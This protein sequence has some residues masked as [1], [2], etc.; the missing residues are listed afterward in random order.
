MGNPVVAITGARLP[1]SDQQFRD[2]SRGNRR[3]LHQNIIGKLRPL[4]LAYHWSF[5]HER[6]RDSGDWTGRLSLLQDDV[7]DIG[8]FYRVYNNF[9]WNEIRHR[10]SVHLFRLGVK[11]IWEDRENWHGGRWTFRVMKKQAEAFFHEIAILCVSNELQAAI[12][13][14][15]WIDVSAVSCLPFTYFVEHDHVLGV[16]YSN[17]GNSCLIS[18]WNKQ[19]RNEKSIRVL[20]RTICSLLAEELQ[21]VRNYFFYKRHD[22]HERFQSIIE[23]SIRETNRSMLSNNIPISPLQTA[24]LDHIDSMLSDAYGN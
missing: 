15:R 2:A 22:E 12:E 3:A 19:G 4:P 13:A 1:L 20:E 8:M 24:S 11:P 6:H 21:P 10:D 23:K 17:R 5:W 14:G 9:P 7:S 16:T 18:V